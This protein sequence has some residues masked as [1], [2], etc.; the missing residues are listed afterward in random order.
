MRALVLVTCAALAAPAC[1]TRDDT[2]RPEAVSQRIVVGAD[3]VAPEVIVSALAARLGAT[4]RGGRVFCAYTPLGQEAN[5]VV[6]WTLCQEFVASGDSVAT[7]TGFSGPALLVMDTEG[8]A[9][10][11]RRRLPASPGVKSLLPPGVMAE[12]TGT[13]FS[14]SRRCGRS[15]SGSTAASLRSGNG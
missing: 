4:S 6:A 8:G 7:E 11:L 3:T 15:V 14:S 13:V 12:L 9:G 5:R 2:D 10:D 1:R